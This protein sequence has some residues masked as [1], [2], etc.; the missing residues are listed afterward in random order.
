M[1]ILFFT[2]FIIISLTSK[3]F[4]KTQFDID[5]FTLG[6]I[7]SDKLT[8]EQIMQGKE[9]KYYNTKYIKT[10]EFKKSSFL[11]N[12]E[13]Y[14]FSFKRNDKKEKIID[15]QVVNYYKDNVWECF[16]KRD[17]LLDEIK[18]KMKKQIKAID[19]LGTIKFSKSFAKGTK[20]ETWVDLKGNKSIYV[21]CYNFDETETRKDQ[22][23]MGISHKYFEKNAFK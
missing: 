17:E 10:L 21:S 16:F 1:K 2:F 11:P 19:D 18:T 6:M 8:P 5:G 15:I 4:A 22:L 13:W 9:E 12:Y 20:T 3:S 23:R 14:Q 7:L